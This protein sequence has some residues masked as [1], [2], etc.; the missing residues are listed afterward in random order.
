MASERT[1]EPAVRVMSKR[2]SWL[3]AVCSIAVIA[4]VVVGCS[5]LMQRNK[6]TD[7]AFV[8]QGW[9]DVALAPGSLVR[10]EARGQE[11]DEPVTYWAR[12]V[13]APD[14]WSSAVLDGYDARFRAAGWT[15]QQDL[16]GPGGGAPRRLC[17]TRDVDGVTQVADI[18]TVDAGEPGADPDEL[19]VTLSSWGRGD[20]PRCGEAGAFV[21]WPT[22]AD[23]PG[24]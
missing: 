6:A 5:W 17:W 16:A 4:L 20:P 14:G 9:D 10:V 21:D 19:E 3:I 24:G 23:K 2:G 22:G 13:T 11:A 1:S 15:P 8:S 12:R 18:R 7:A